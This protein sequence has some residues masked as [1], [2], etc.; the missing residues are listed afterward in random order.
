MMTRSN[1][2]SRQRSAGDAGRGR[3]PGA[4]AGSTSLE[5]V[6]LAPALLLVIAVVIAGGRVSTAHTAVLV[7]AE[8]AARQASL[9]RTVAGAQAAAQAEASASLA[10]QGVACRATT[11]SISTG[12]FAVA[13][14]QAAAVSAEVS[15]DV[16]LSDLGLPGPGAITVS[17]SATSVLDTYRER[18]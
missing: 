5:F 1:R 10:G 2:G 3:G 14:G 9:A 18:P 16:P 17:E 6:V 8:A 4:D 11:I 7:A 13:V 15:C 12:G